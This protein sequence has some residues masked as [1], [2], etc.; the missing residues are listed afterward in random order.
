MPIR[1]LTIE[2]DAAPVRRKGIAARVTA[3][4]RGH[5]GRVEL[6]VTE[7]GGR[8][9]AYTS[10]AV[11][12]DGARRD[13]IRALGGVPADEVGTPHPW[14]WPTCWLCGDPINP[15]HHLLRGQRRAADARHVPAGPAVS[16]WAGTPGCTPGVHNDGVTTAPA[17][18]LLRTVADSRAAR[19]ARALTPAV[20]VPTITCPDLTLLQQVGDRDTLG[21]A[22]LYAFWRADNIGPR[23]DETGTRGQVFHTDVDKL[24][25]R[26]ER[27]GHRVQ[28]LPPLP[29]RPGL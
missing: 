9:T 19:A 17:A 3:A 25:A 6:A 10:A 2:E 12:G 23:L 16:G 27:V 1:H 11:I 20:E 4:L 29:A 18:P 15:V 13:L 14:G 7:V 8:G 21:R 26:L 24:I 28:W 5:A 22:Y